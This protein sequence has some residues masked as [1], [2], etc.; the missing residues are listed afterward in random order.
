MASSWLD[1]M[2]NN[3]HGKKRLVSEIEECSPVSH[4]VLLDSPMFLSRN[5]SYAMTSFSRLL[6]YDGPSK[7]FTTWRMLALCMSRLDRPTVPEVPDSPY[8]PLYL[9][10]SVRYRFK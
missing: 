9:F 3:I 10:L 6:L 8:A 1:Q 2:N 7:N 5:A 4:L